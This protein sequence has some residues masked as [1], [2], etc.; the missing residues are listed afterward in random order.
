MAHSKT[1]VVH[2]L[3]IVS[4][5]DW[6]KN[7]IANDIKDGWVKHLD[8]QI[9]DML[10]AKNLPDDI[11]NRGLSVDDIETIIDSNFKK[12]KD[13]EKI[14]LL[15]DKW[16]KRKD[17]TIHQ[18]FSEKEGESLL[19]E[20]IKRLVSDDYAD[21]YLIEDWQSKNSEHKFR[22]ILLR[23]INT[24]SMDCALKLADGILEESASEKFFRDNML[25]QSPG[26]ELM[27]YVDAEIKSPFIEYILHRFANNFTRIGVEDLPK[28]DTTD[29]LVRQ[30]KAILI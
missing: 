21:F 12:T 3:P 20:N 19:K 17:F 22:V 9:T 2:Y 4:F 24:L 1:N 11:F 14:R 25:A 7:E 18:I 13:K 27:Y 6:V 5:E 28:A 29:L 30:T 26:R 16:M 15:R 10:R 23:T 8:S